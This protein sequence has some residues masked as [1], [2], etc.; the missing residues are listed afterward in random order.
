[1]WTAFERRASDRD[2]LKVTVEEQTT[3]VRRQ[4]AEAESTVLHALASARSAISVQEE[5]LRQARLEVERRN[6]DF[7]TE[8]QFAEIL[9]VSVP[10]IAKLRKD[11]DLEPIYVASLPRYLRSHHVAKASEIFSKKKKRRAKS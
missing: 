4:L 11:G 5:E 2:R 9:Q 3:D 8:E 1:M 10:T 7:L 6:D